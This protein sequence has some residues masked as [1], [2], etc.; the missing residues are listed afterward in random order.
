[1]E[2][3]AGELRTM[4]SEQQLGAAP[5]VT[6]WRFTGEGVEVVDEQGGRRTARF[7]PTPEGDWLAPGAAARAAREQMEAGAEEISVTT[8]D[9]SQGL[10]AVT[11]TRRLRGQGPVEAMGKVVPA[12]EWVVT[13]DSFPGVESVEFLDASGELVRGTTDM[14]GIVVEML[15]SDRAV[16]T[17]D[18]PAPELLASTLVTPDRPIR[19]AR[20]VRTGAY[21]LRLR[22]GEMPDL[23]E[24]G[25]QRVERLDGRSARVVVDLTSPRL[26]AGADADDAAYLGSSRMIDATDPKIVELAREAVKPVAGEPAHVRAER[27]RRFVYAYIDAKSLDVGFAT[28]S[29]T[30]RTR[31]G[32]CTEHGVLLAAL[33]RAEGIP[34]RVVSGVLYV[35][36]FIGREGVFGFHMWTQALLDTGDG[37]R[38]VD[39]DATLDDRTPT[40]ATHIAM[41]V[42]AMAA[43]D[44]FNTMASLAPL[45]GGLEIVVERVE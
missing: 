44:E 20:G 19:G 29:E 10:R 25:V 24:T 9:P 41:A 11:S 15:A 5:L 31:Q 37:P 21:V 16:A 2:S 33:L 12:S 38:W 17:A 45:L 36:E 3:A 26:A 23:P 4:R 6:T 18:V 13:I 32:D 35:D 7:E 39:L 30:A 1:M 14:G 34:S 40:D 22:Q 42:S 43:D 8:L 28:A 27:M